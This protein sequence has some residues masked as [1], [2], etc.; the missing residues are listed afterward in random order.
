MSDDNRPKTIEAALAQVAHAA[1]V[2][3][4]VQFSAMYTIDDYPIGRRDRG[5]CE[6]SYEY[7][8]KKREWRTSRRTTDKYGRWC[9]PKCSVY[10]DSPMVIVSGPDLEHEA[11]WLRTDGRSMYLQWANGASEMLCQAPF[12]SAPNREARTVTWTTRSLSYGANGYQIDDVVKQ[13]TDTIPADPPEHIALWDAYIEAYKPL[14]ELVKQRSREMLE[15]A[16][17][18]AE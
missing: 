3:E 12:W 9:K 15:Q 2:L 1:K 14:Y 10:V 7:H 11:A 8:P 17:A 6:M 18:V 13:E 5:R 4:V 16:A